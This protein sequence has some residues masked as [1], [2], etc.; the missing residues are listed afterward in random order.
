MQKT[1]TIFTPAYNRAH[2]IGRTYESLCRQT[3][4]DFEWLIID[5]GSK[6]NTKELIFSWI[7]KD[8]EFHEISDNEFEGYSEDA[9]WLHIRYCHKENGGLHTGYNKAIELMDTELC[10]CIDSDDWMPDDAVEKIIK[11]WEK[12]GDDGVGGI[13][14]LDFYENG[15][16]IGGY[17]ENGIERLKMI[18][19]R[20]KYHHKGDVKVVHRTEIL[21]RI[22]PMPSFPGE[23]N[24]NPIYLFYE[25]DVKYPLLLLNDNI[26]FVEY[27]NDGMSNNMIR[28]YVNSPRSFSELRKQMMRRPDVS[29]NMKF[30]N[31][32][33]YVSSQIMIGNRK[34]LAESPMKFMT[35]LAVP[36]GVILYLVIMYKYKILS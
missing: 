27:Q 18:E 8:Y 32:I 11:K 1:L 3:C 9:S 14:G 17:F 12:E 10:V 13:L 33:H 35:I 24:F 25:I 23:K 5:D 6:D 22:P 28:Q 20:S 21:K 31:A 34:W 19:M 29:I 30:K 15:E 26:C 36:F 2:T 16:P 7:T 4:Q